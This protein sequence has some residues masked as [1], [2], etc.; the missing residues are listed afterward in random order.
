MSAQKWTLAWSARNPVFAVPCDTAQAHS[1]WYL[2]HTQPSTSED[3]MIKL[4]LLVSA[5]LVMGTIVFDAT[6]ASTKLSAC[7]VDN[8]GE[9]AVWANQNPGVGYKTACHDLSGS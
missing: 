4:S 1:V 9:A 6:N 7:D 3:D 2:E 8:R 5:A